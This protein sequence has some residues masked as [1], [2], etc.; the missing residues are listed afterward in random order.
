MTSHP[1]PRPIPGQMW[2]TFQANYLK[3]HKI[4]IKK[5]VINNCGKPVI[6]N[7]HNVEKK[8]STCWLNCG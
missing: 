7:T 8:L 5:R 3:L 6:H 1:Y 2:I 4:K